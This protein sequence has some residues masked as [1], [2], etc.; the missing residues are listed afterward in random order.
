[1]MMM[2]MMM[3]LIMTMMMVD[4]GSSV[5]QFVIGGERQTDRQTDGRTGRQAGRQTE[6]LRGGV[7][8]IKWRW[9]LLF[10]I[11]F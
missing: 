8:A 5:T 1:M 4:K 6:T 3:L 7:D 2:M 10:L 9:R 11:H